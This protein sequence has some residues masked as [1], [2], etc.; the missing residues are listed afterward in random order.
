MFIHRIQTK[1]KD[2]FPAVLLIRLYALTIDLSNQSFY[3]K[4]RMQFIDILKQFLNNMHI[5]KA[6]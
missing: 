1:I 6:L 3:I 4:E 2:I 5:L